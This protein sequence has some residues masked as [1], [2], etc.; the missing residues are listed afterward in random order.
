MVLSTPTSPLEFIFLTSLYP[1]ARAAFDAS[2]YLSCGLLLECTAPTSANV[3]V[4]A[5]VV[6][7][8]SE[9]AFSSIGIL[10]ATFTLVF[11]RGDP[12]LWLFG[13]LS[14]LL[15]RGVFYPVEVLPHFLRKVPQSCCR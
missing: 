11:K 3:L 14:W 9:L 5:V 8:V 10:S 12:I 15:G 6:F 13:G 2:I 7:L 1:I 4:S